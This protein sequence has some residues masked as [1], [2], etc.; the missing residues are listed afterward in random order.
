VADKDDTVRRAD[1]LEY[2]Y[3]LMVEESGHPAQEPGHGYDL[4]RRVHRFVTDLP[5]TE[6]EK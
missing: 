4:A 3:Q 1:I 6:T 5:A 2:V